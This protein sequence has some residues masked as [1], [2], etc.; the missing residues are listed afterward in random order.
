MII[1]E[2]TLER[3]TTS[4]PTSISSC[5]TR[6]IYIRARSALIP[7]GISVEDAIQFAFMRAAREGNAN[8]LFE[9]IDGYAF[10]RI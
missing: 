6:E 9:R 7:L 4:R 2:E 5:I 10:E 1:R 8:F 3:M